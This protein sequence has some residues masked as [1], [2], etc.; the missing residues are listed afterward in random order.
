VSET[1]RRAPAQPDRRRLLPRGGGRRADDKDPDHGT[2]ARYQRGCPCLPCRA[3]NAEYIAFGRDRK[4]K[5]LPML[6]SVVEAF[7]AWRQLR[8]LTREYARE[9]GTGGQAALS[10]RLGLKNGHL[11]QATRIKSGLRAGRRARIRLSTALRIQ[12]L[13]QID[14]LAGLE[15]P[16]A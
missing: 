15:K 1:D 12:R 8:L 11:Q 2:R 7:D 14:I 10:R 16:Y 13:Y 4:R 3:A 5:G 6:G 9:D